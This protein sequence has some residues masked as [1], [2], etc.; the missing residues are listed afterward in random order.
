VKLFSYLPEAHHNV[1]VIF[2]VSPLQ[3]GFK[4]GIPR[5]AEALIDHLYAY[6]G[7]FYISF[8]DTN[9]GSLNPASK[10]WKNIKQ[11]T[12]K[13]EC[14]HGA[15]KD[16]DNTRI[17]GADQSLSYTWVYHNPS[18]MYPEDTNDAAPF[19]LHKRKDVRLVAT[20]HDLI[21]YFII[22]W[23]SDGYLQR[24]RQLERMDAL[25]AISGATAQHLIDHLNYPKERIF[26]ARWGADPTFKPITHPTPIPAHTAGESAIRKYEE[27]KKELVSRAIKKLSETIPTLKELRPGFI[28]CL[29]APDPRK[30]AQGVVSAYAMLPKEVR[31]RHQLVHG[32]NYDASHKQMFVNMAKAIDPSF[33]ENEILYTE[34]ELSEEQLQM[35]YQT[36]D[37]NIMASFFE[38]FGMPLV[39]GMA[40]DTLTLAAKTSST[41]EIVSIPELQFDPADN[42]DISK[43]MAHALNVI[44]TDIVK[45][46]ELRNAQLETVAQTFSWRKCMQS[47]VSA[48]TLAS[49]LPPL[50][51]VND[52]EPLIVDFVRLGVAVFGEWNAE[53]KAFLRRLISH[54]IKTNS[55][56]KYHLQVDFFTNTPIGEIVL[57]TDDFFRAYVRFKETNQYQVEMA[58]SFVVLL[59]E[60]QNEFKYSKVYALGA[61]KHHSAVSPISISLENG[62][63]VIQN[64]EN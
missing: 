26:I 45:A 61:V 30:N 7:N 42:K 8:L 62:P 12:L 2:N 28:F 50:R 13:N 5:T 52:K 60:S 6:L 25:V 37:L 63:Q 3:W 29:A 27:N 18:G 53:N 33:E 16:C 46:R 41:G 39:E 15:S 48:F 1:R 43:T 35:V 59:S 4:R 20:I 9:G 21:P 40:S 32:A 17:L 34:I 14:P 10:E 56:R 11:I 57:L 23:Q 55:L 44:E 31:K 49:N 64:F 22:D 47:Y 36:A 19:V 54:F 24:L 58:Y 51:N 38:G